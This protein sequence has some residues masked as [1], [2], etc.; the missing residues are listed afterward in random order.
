MPRK[1]KRPK[2]RKVPEVTPLQAALSGALGEQFAALARAMVEEEIR[3]RQAVD[4]DKR[5]RR[6]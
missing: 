3:R 5:R 1:A 4:P 2:A 6:S